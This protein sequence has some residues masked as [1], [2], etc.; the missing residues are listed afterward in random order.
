MEKITKLKTDLAAMFTPLSE[1]VNMNIWELARMAAGMQE[2]TWK[3]NAEIKHA[4]KVEERAGN[5]I[6]TRFKEADW[7]FLSQFI[8]CIVLG[9]GGIGSN[10]GYYLGKT[11][12]GRLWL[13]DMDRV[14]EHNVGTQFFGR[15]DIRMLKTDALRNFLSRQVGNE[16][17]NSMTM[18]IT[19]DYSGWI[20]AINGKSVVI[21][22]FDNMTAREISYKQWVDYWTGNVRYGSG[23]KGHSGHSQLN[24]K[25][26]D[27]NYLFSQIPPI[28]IDG[29]LNA[30][31]YEI[32][33]VPFGD[34]EAMELY[35]REFLFAE[36]EAP[37]EQCTLKQ[38]PYSAGMIAARICQYVCAHIENIAHGHDLISIPFRTKE[39]LPVGQILLEEVYH[40]TEKEN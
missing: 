25:A 1:L 20:G 4:L 31:E 35:E 15:S 22:G 2:L 9:V 6:H 16:K 21:T 23:L 27:F 10:L 12:P 37:E 26:I 34:Q 29:R 38:T 8:D 17:V 5:R 32:L 7:Y 24:P 40:Y 13:V 11:L 19:E 36:S 39:I 14:E 18:Q 33:V 3:D 30:N 28:F